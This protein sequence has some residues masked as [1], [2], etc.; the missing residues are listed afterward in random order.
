M[1][2]NRTWTKTSI[3]TQ[4]E[5][6]KVRESEIERD[7]ERERLKKREEERQR[8]RETLCSVIL[9]WVSE[10]RSLSIEILRI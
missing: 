7:K 1:K 2:Y 4:Q 6:E 3:V 10:S 8:M 5:G 9:E